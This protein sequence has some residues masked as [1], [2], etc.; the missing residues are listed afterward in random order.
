[1]SF[2]RDFGLALKSGGHLSALERT[3]IGTFKI[4]N[5]FDIKKFQEYIEQIQQN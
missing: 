5:A 4:N 3:A 1:M 2:A